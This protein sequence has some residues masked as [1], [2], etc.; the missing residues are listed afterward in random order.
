MTRGIVEQHSQ[1]NPVVTAIVAAAGAGKVQVRWAGTWVYLVTVAL[2]KMV[3][4]AVLIRKEKET[5][6]NTML[7]VAL[8][9]TAYSLLKIVLQ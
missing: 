2:L 3:Q 8:A 6:K 4:A 7:H 5:A 9:D 1:D